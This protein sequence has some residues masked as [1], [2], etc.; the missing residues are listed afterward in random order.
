MSA[1]QVLLAIDAGNT[2]ITVGLFAGD[3]LTRREQ[4]RHDQLETLFGQLASSPPAA[5]WRGAVVASVVPSLDNALK[6]QCEQVTGTAP[7]FID[8]TA[9]LGIAIQTDAPEQTGA[10]RLVNA[11]A[12][13]HLYGGPVV[14]VDVGTCVTVCAVTADGRYLGGAIAPGPKAGLAALSARAEKLPPVAL[15]A[16]EGPIGS[17]TAEAMRAGVVIGFAGLVDRLVADTAAAL[18]KAGENKVEGGRVV[19]TGGDAGLLIPHLHT[20]C[21]QVDDLLLTGLKRLFDRAG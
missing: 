15:S 12:A 21:R 18:E 8:H 11:A 2:S 1:K 10:D 14:V 16:P 20:A 17:G 3:R 6:E 5:G 9:D 4:V 7:L 19:I 13:W